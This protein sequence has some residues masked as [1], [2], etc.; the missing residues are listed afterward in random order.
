MASFMSLFPSNTREKFY[1][2]AISSV[3]L[4]FEAIKFRPNA[5][6]VV[7][8][9]YRLLVRLF[10]VLFVVT[11][12]ISDQK[13]SAQSAGYTAALNRVLARPSDP[14]ASFVFAQVA[15][16]EGDFRG[17]ITAL[18]R[19]LT[20]NPQ[21]SNI[22]L[23]LGV[24]YLQTGA[25]EAGEA[26]IRDALRAEDVPD[27]VRARAEEF[28]GLA[29]TRNQ[30][31]RFSGSIAS[32]LISDSN[33]NSAPTEDSANI[34]VSDEAD[35]SAYL[36]AA[37]RLAWDLGF[38]AGHTFVIDANYYRR[39]Y[40]DLSELDL[41]RVALSAGVDLNLAGPGARPTQLSLRVDGNVVWRD[42]ERYLTELGPSATLRTVIDQRTS[43][44][45]SAYFRNQDYIPTSVVTAN[46]IRDGDITGGALRFDRTINER[47]SAFVILSAFDKSAEV[48][49]EAYKQVALTAGYAMS[50]DPLFTLGK[51][52]PWV[53]SIN[54]RI[55]RN[56][57]DGPDPNFMADVTRKDTISTI[58]G[59]VAVPLNDMALL[60]VEVGYTDQ[61]SNRAVNDFDNAFGSIGLRYAF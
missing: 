6:A 60:S 10:C 28:L 41:D 23:E 2:L 24:L 31:F 9:I 53:L 18:E 8:Q 45:I 46:D 12:G 36:Q 59:G 16:Q 43:A 30:R 51:N 14:E 32:G 44:Q 7:S 33:A 58:S 56:T 55:A 49:F 50:I 34:I 57:Y 19:I 17:A 25:T 37:A 3:S 35:T 61:S 1:F 40:S 15:A 27:P 39:M 52:A 29:E 5:R 20:L 42:G 22:K 48:N 47:A 21:L 54:A 26:L 4:N 13:A 38:Q 11:L